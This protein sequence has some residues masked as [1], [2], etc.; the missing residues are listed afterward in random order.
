M[1][2]TPAKSKRREHPVDRAPGDSAEQKEAEKLLV[3]WLSER[4]GVKLET[5]RLPLP[6]GGWLEI[7]GACESPP[8]LCEAWA[9]QG[10]PK[11]GQKQKV[12][13]DAFKLIYAGQLVS[14]RPR[15]ILLFGDVE[16]ASHFKGTSWMAQAIRASGIEVRVAELPD[17]VRAMIRKAQARQFR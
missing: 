16:A 10:P 17:P 11:S 5:A 2:A 8:I 12:V 3:D 13:T 1:T 9:H 6:S 15:L 14:G 7:D 4:L